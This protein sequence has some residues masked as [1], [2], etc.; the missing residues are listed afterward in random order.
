MDICP[1]FKGYMPDI[2]VIY[3]RYSRYICP[4]FNGNMPDIQ[5][6]YA[7]YPMENVK[8]SKAVPQ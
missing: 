3:A 2:Q 4:I 1:L 8:I 6:K 5:K 7:R